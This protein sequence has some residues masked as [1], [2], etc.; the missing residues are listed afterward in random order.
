MKINPTNYNM[1]VSSHMMSSAIVLEIAG[2]Q[3]VDRVGAVLS[4]TKG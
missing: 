4:G 1:H 3:R 2:M